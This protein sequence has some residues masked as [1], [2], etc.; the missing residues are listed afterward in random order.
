MSRR[1]IPYLSCTVPS[2]KAALLKTGFLPPIHYVCVY[3]KHFPTLEGSLQGQIRGIRINSWFLIHKDRCGNRYNVCV[4]ACVCI[5]VFPSVS[6][7]SPEAVT[8]SSNEH[9]SIQNTIF[10]NA[11]LLQSKQVLHGEMIDY[12]I[13][14]GKKMGWEHLVWQGVEKWSKNHRDR[15]VE[16]YTGQSDGASSR[17]TGNNY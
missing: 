3:L 1:T 16:Q 10:L 14:M 2:V 5:Q 4:Y 15:Q 11:I 8:P 12:Q 13:G 7:D 9:T 17:Q 6:C